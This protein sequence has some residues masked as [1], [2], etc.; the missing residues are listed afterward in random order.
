[1]G[2]VWR[3]GQQRKCFIYRMITRGTIEETILK[4][5]LKKGALA[6]VI[7]AAEPEAGAEAGAEEEARREEAEGVNGVLEMVMRGR[8]AD[9]ANDES[10]QPLEALVLPRGR[11][12]LAPPC[13]HPHQGQGQ[14]AGS[15]GTDAALAR[16][17]D[18]AC[19]LL[20]EVVAA[21]Q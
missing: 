11:A 3:D 9:E 20:I 6:T 16:V 8:G 4:R 15:A 1:M 13:A 7:A 18:E 14:G 17:L 5:Q 10:T 19:P 12:A 2:R 21:P